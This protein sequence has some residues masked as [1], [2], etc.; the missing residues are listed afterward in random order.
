M[1]CGSEDIRTLLRLNSSFPQCHQQPRI[2]LT[3]QL[4]QQ[5]STGASWA[6]AGVFLG[7]VSFHVCYAGFPLRAHTSSPWQSVSAQA[8]WHTVPWLKCPMWKVLYQ[9]CNHLWLEA[10]FASDMVGVTRKLGMCRGWL[11]NYSF[12]C[13]CLSFLNFGRW[14]LRLWVPYRVSHGIYMEKRRCTDTWKPFRVASKLLSA[15]LFECSILKLWLMTWEVEISS[16]KT[17]EAN[18][19]LR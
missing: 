2:R 7:G 3:W 18:Q 19:V 17:T 6:G 13:S 12:L 16:T 15:E 4:V 14:M 5:F 11:N 9:L 8:S 10:G 1:F